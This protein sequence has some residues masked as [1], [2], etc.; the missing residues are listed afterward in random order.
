MPNIFIKSKY[1]AFSWFS[2]KKGQD[3]QLKAMQS[4]IDRLQR[5]LNSSLHIYPTYGSEK[6]A[7]R[8][9]TTD[10][11]YAVVSRL[12][13]TA[14][15]IPLY[16]YQVK[17]DKA[18][19]QLSRLSQP[20]TMPLQT[21]A[22]M[23]KALEDLP[24]NDPLEK[25]LDNP[26]SHMSRFE[27]FE[28]LHIL[29]YLE[30][31]AFIY[32][33]K[34]SE[35][36][37]AGKPVELYVLHPSN[38]NLLVSTT[39]PREVM[40]YEYVMDGQVVY[41]SMPVEDVIH[42][43]YFNPYSLHSVDGLRGLSP[44]KVLAKRLTQNDGITDVSTAQMQNGGVKTFIYEEG[45]GMTEIDGKEV[46][47]AGL[48]KDQFYR[49]ISNTANAGSPFFDTSGGKV[50]AI[51]LGSTLAD[52]QVIEAAKVN[53]KKICNVYAVSDRLFN[54]DA[55]GSEVSDDN[56]N[57]GLY[58]NAVLPNVYRVRDALN[59][60]LLPDFK[61]KKRQI[62]EDISEIPVLQADMKRMA[63]WLGSSWWITPNEKREMMKFDAIDE[64]L[65]N[66]PLI[67]SGL[68]TLEDLTIIDPIEPSEES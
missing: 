41:K 3:V 55:T 18:A 40:G 50:T 21:K 49:F 32:K 10:D 61:D 34:P 14:A 33:A 1:V 4:N 45:D 43:K 11:I 15:L 7:E 35:G 17:D 66:Q 6:S 16:A 25:I 24:E 59:K 67:P 22:M 31:E 64:G 46:S 19:K 42:I 13:R 47:I 44:I 65:F 28:A 63:E 23:I 9:T 2:K 62:R 26:N 38:V 54:N 68:Q 27:F 30:G 5:M 51:P 8:Y 60:S 57:M 37:N 56:A 20:H 53:F 39:L 58:T 36:V 48:R 29:L 12:A 52:M